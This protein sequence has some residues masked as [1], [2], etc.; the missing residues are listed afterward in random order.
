MIVPTR[1]REPPTGDTHDITFQVSGLHIWTNQLMAHM[2]KPVITVKR[3]KWS[4]VMRR[5]GPAQTVAEA[6]CCAR[7]VVWLRRCR[8]LVYQRGST[9]NPALNPLARIIADF[10]GIGR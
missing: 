1:M 4:A 7:C 10:H 8:H 6:P 3:P 5:S 9:P 2:M